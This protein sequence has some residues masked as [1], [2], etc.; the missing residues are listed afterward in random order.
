M[1]NRR[2]LL[3]SAPLAAAG[4]IGLSAL[5]SHAQ[6]EKGMGE[7]APYA[8]PALPYAYDALEP[9]IDKETMKLH[10]DIHHAGY[11]KGL[12]ATLEKLAAAR[13]GGDFAATKALSRDLAFNGSGHLLHCCFWTNMAPPSKAEPKG[14]LNRMLD[15]D[16][17][18]VDA[19]KAQFG[20]AAKQVEGSGWAILGYEPLSKRLLVVEAEKHQ[21]LTMWGI[22][23]LLVID[24]WEHAYYLKYQ[25]K[26][27]DY[28]DAFWNIVHWDNVSE[29][30]DAAMK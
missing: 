27:A 18:S 13:K 12:N 5:A 23:P 6:E 19:F 3:A 9:V 21:N 16:F 11:V 26:R 2:D 8:L 22:H 10:H 28:V 17:G 14:M 20:N 4:W 1:L 29:R 30:L 24:V 15:R 7:P 25:N